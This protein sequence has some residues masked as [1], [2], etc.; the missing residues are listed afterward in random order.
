MHPPGTPYTIEVNPTIPPRLARLEELANNL[1][2]SW[3]RPT[4]ALFA[5]LHPG[6]WDAVGHNPKAFLKR[7]D[8][9]RLDAAAEDPVVPRQLQPRAVGLRHVS[10]RAA[11]RNGAPALRDKRPGRLLLRRVRLSRKP[12][13]LLRRPRHPRRRPLQGGERPAPAASSA[14]G[15]LYRQGY[16]SQTID[17]EGNQHATY[18][19]SDFDDLPTRPRRGARRHRARASTVELP[20]RDVTRKVWQ[21]RVGHVTLYLLDTDVEENSEHD[22]DITHRLYGGDRATRIEQEIVLGIGGVRALAALGLKPTVWHINEGHAA[23]LVLE[24]IRAARC[25]QGLDFASALEAVAANTVFTTHTAVPAGHDHFADDMM[26]QL[27]RRATAGDVGIDATTLLALGRT[28]GERRLQHDG[29]RRCAA[30]ALTTAYRAST[31]ASR[32]ACCAASGRRSRPRKTR[33]IYVT[34]GVHVPTFLAPEWDDVVRALPRARLDAAPAAD[35]GVL[36]RDRSRFRTICSGA[37][38]ST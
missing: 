21:A 7:V 23:F 15:L 4:R 28:P 17:A 2:Y 31:A 10:R 26:A 34:N 20:G 24:R 12:A 13:D 38:A 35:R 6:L 18:A 16:F 19:D 27:F 5:R 14:S 29:A 1:W 25:R 8:E 3:D 36:E 11:A 37:C 30:R 32:R 33:S 9:R 22:R